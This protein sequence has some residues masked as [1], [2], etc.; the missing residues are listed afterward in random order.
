MSLYFERLEDSREETQSHS[1]GSESLDNNADFPVGS[2]MGCA[3]S[4][5]SENFSESDTEPEMEDRRQ[6]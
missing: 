1:S 3:V 5:E 4:D 2:L 6:V